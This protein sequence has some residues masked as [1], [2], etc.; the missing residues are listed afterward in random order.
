MP[1]YYFN[2]NHRDGTTPDCDGT[3][4]PDDAAAGLHAG[5]VARELLRHREAKRRSW[6]LQVCDAARAPLFELL[7]ADVDP[8]LDHLSPELKASLNDV[9]LKASRMNDSIKDVRASIHQLRGTLACAD[10]L[11]WLAAINGKR[12]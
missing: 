10:G 11:P 6:C 2:L 9:S 7:F 5:A 1:L 12:L 8:S 4:L 3:D